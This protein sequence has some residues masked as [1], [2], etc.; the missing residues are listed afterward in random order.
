MFC[1]YPDIV[2]LIVYITDGQNVSPP[3]L[4]PDLKKFEKPQT[5]VAKK[6]AGRRKAAVTGGWMEH[7]T[8]PVCLFPFIYA[9]TNK[10]TSIDPPLMSKAKNE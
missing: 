2:W 6:V 8:L 10:E 1:T 5:A 3:S 7:W 9:H 4:M